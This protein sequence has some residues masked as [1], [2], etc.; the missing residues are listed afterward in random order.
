MLLV[1]SQ[2][3]MKNMYWKVEEKQSFHQPQSE[4]LKNSQIE[5]KSHTKEWQIKTWQIMKARDDRI[6]SSKCW[7]QITAYFELYILENSLS[8]LKVK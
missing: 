7:K 4:D 2:K 6:I 5:D 8:K 3:E 1:R